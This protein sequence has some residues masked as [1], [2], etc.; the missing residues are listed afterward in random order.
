MTNLLGRYYEE[1]FFI[2]P[3]RKNEKR[4]V[5]RKWN[6]YSASYNESKQ[7]VKHGYNLGVV[8]GKQSIKEGYELAIIDI[9]SRPVYQGLKTEWQEY[10]HSFNTWIQLTPGG[11]FHI[12][13]R[14]KPYE[15]I[16][17]LKDYMTKYDLTPHRTTL[18]PKHQENTFANVS[19]VEHDRYFADTIRSTS[20]YAL[21]A[22]SKIDGKS[23]WWLDDCKGE[24]LKL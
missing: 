12:F 18:E 21:V 20:M 23:Y 7:F 11:G 10:F 4:P 15:N 6:E 3:I 19:Q 17:K 16:S 22:P 1:N 2:I 5:Y 14:V 8:S 24:I 13:L 9:D